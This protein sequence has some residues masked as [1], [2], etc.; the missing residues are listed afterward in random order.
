MLLEPG[1]VAVKKY[2]RDAGSRAVV[3]KVLGNGFVNVITSVRNR[4]RRCNI[5]HL[6]FLD[7]KVDPSDK[8]MVGKVLGISDKEKQKSA[9][10]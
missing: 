10:K 6:E 5:K 8:A 9:S 3:T 4:E 1:R 7:E 2:G